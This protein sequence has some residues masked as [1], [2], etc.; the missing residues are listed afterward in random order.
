MVANERQALAESFR[1]NTEE[2]ARLTFNHRA[3]D[4]LQDI[5]DTNFKFYKQVTDNDQFA[6]AFFGW[7][8]ER[9][10]EGVEVRGDNDL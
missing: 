2:N 5:I 6:D 1:V 3:M 9:Y 10:Q 7:M 4:N 8:F